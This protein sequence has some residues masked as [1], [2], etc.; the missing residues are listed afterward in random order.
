M[1]EPNPPFRRDILV[2]A[3][4]GVASGLIS[5][6][7]GNVLSPDWLRFSFIPFGWHSSAAPVVPGLVFGVLVAACCRHY[8]T[9][10]W[11]AQLGAVLVTTAAW[12]YAFDLTVLADGRIGDLRQISDI[13]DELRGGSGGHGGGGQGGKNGFVL[14]AAVSFGLG[15]LVGGFG[16]ALAAA[17]FR[18]A[19]AWV[20]TV[21]VATV[22]GAIENLYGLVGGDAALMALFMCWQAGVI[23]TL[24]HG[25][26][27]ESKRE[28]KQESKQEST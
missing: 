14:G 7:A 21:V 27:Q 22:L 28:S 10:D 6:L 17:R 9:K 11:W 5:W 18:R 20:L 16:T 4:L 3:A 12:I 1:T 25:L 24:A 15:G 2:F 23:A 26:S 13:I 19:S 8:G